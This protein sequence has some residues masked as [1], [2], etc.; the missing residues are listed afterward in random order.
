MSGARATA[1]KVAAIPTTAKAPGCRV[2]PPTVAARSAN[3]APSAAP[4]NRLGMKAPP[5]PPD[6]RVRAVASTLAS[7]IPP[8][9]YQRIDSELIRLINPTTYPCP[10]PAT[11]G[12]TATA[13]A[14]ANP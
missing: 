11:S 1:A 8:S 12:T 6:P 5:E 9:E 13:A 3:P 14:T 7:A 4:T 2:I 10:V